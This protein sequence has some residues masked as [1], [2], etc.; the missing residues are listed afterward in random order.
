MAEYEEPQWAEVALSVYELHGT[1]AI[2]YLTAATG[3]GGAYHVGVEV[4]GLEWS[5]GATDVGTGI[6]MVHP[7]QSTLGTFY[8]RIPLGK[9]KISPQ[10]NLE[11]LGEYRRMFR[12]QQY[13]LLAKNCAHFCL[14]FSKRLVPRSSPPDWINAFANYGQSLTGAQARTSLLEIEEEHL[15]LDE[16]DDDE[17]EEFAHDGDHIAMVELVWRRGKEYTLEW[18]QQQQHNAKYEDL[19][20][21]IRFM[22]PRDDKELR[23]TAV[24]LMRD[25]QL[26]KAVADSTATALELQWDGPDLRPLEISKFATL[27]SYRISAACRVTG[28]Q[29]IEQLKKKPTLEEF[30]A[31]FKK[32]MKRAAA[33]TPK[34]KVLIE[35]MLVDTSPGMPALHQRVLTRFDCHDTIRFPRD[36][37]KPPGSSVDT[38]LRKLQEIRS[39]VQDQSS[40]HRTLT[41]MMTPKPCTPWWAREP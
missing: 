19:I 16:F 3:I 21:E 41:V 14:A 1:G 35:S 36:D 32:A 29:H 31:K 8:E 26:K 6:Y 7:Q 5:F 40:T 12:G 4:Y 37:F 13:H 34:Q 22:V 23:S 33:W 25:L 38:M 15:N 9:T 18:V 30:T 11:I 10:Q 24:G 17:L 2:N 20:V 27:P 28:G 39:A